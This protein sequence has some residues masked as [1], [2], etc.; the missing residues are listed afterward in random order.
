MDEIS[1]L[2]T[3]PL[4][5]GQ[6]MGREVPVLQVTP[7]AHPAT[8]ASTPPSWGSKTHLINKD[9]FMPSS[10]RKYQ[11]FGEFLDRHRPWNE[12]EISITNYSLTVT[13]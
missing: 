9:T 12:G 10:H 8:S 13:L 6:G 7:W 5:G 1:G 2:Q 3:P 11:G 4:P